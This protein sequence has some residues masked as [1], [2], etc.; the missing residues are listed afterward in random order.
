MSP[1]LHNSR[2][3]G[4]I[5][6]GVRIPAGGVVDVEDE[7][8]AD[9]LLAI[10][11]VDEVSRKEAQKIDAEPKRPANINP[12]ISNEGAISTDD[13]AALRGA[14]ER[15]AQAERETV[16]ENAA[17]DEVVTE[18]HPAGETAKD[19]ELMGV[20]ELMAFAAENGIDIGR[21]SS[22]DG[23]LKKIRE[24]Q[25]ANPVGDDAPPTNEEENGDGQ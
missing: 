16:E 20:E 1:L 11:G 15:A 10:D 22:A 4:V 7:G 8:V 21:A 14:L 9:A 24:H 5:S 17:G 25:D 3:H 23:I 19:L 2:H 12:T 6:R 18:S 13:A